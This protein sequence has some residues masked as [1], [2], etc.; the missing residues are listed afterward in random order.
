MEHKLIY[1]FPGEIEI[2][3]QYWNQLKSHRYEVLKYRDG[4]FEIAVDGYIQ[5]KTISVRYSY[6]DRDPLVFKTLADARLA[7][8]RIKATDW[9]SHTQTEERYRGQMIPKHKVIK[10]IPLVE[11]IPLGHQC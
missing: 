1:P 2:A 9:Q 10:R 8:A 5:Y 7:L 11:K 6:Y 3:E 4:H